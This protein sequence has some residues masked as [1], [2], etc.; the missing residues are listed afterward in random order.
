MLGTERALVLARCDAL[1]ESSKPRINLLIP[2][3]SDPNSFNEIDVILSEIEENEARQ[4]RTVYS[5]IE[6]FAI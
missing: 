2:M 6:S 5:A 3:M 4:K 1:D